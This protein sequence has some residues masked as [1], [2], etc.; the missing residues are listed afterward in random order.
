[1]ASS[2]PAEYPEWT[3]TS[4]KRKKAYDAVKSAIENPP[5]KKTFKS[6]AVKKFKDNSSYA[7]YDYDY[8]N[9][10]KANCVEFPSESF[11]EIFLHEVPILFTTIAIDMI[12]E[13][14][15]KRKE[16]T[17]KGPSTGP[18]MLWHLLPAVMVGVENT[19]WSWHITR[20]KE[21]HEVDPLICHIDYTYGDRGYDL[22]VPQKKFRMVILSK[23]KTAL[24]ELFT[25]HFIISE[26]GVVYSNKFFNGQ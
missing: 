12:A 14:K 2:T 11:I 5:K 25:K 24:K 1:M 4:L 23:V 21:G 10:R 13:E 7:S 3:S 19:P 16:D 26:V 20:V 6:P 18:S 17:L 22:S 15:E 8:W 9:E